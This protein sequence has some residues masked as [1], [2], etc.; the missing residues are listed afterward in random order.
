VGIPSGGEGMN[1]PSL[2]GT[3][4]VT[5]FSSELEPVQTRITATQNGPVLTLESASFNATL[6][7][8]PHILRL[9]AAKLGKVAQA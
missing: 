6:P 2:P 7:A 4:S 3:L 8:S 1:L 9:L 5:V